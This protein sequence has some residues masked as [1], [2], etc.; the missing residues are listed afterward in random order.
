M[1]AEA[2]QARARPAKTWRRRFL[3]P[4][5][6]IVAVAILWP[7]WANEPLRR[8][9]FVMNVP[10]QMATGATAVGAF[11]PQRDGLIELAIR[12]PRG[13]DV[14]RNFMKAR[15]GPSRGTPVMSA[16]YELRT[17]DALVASDTIGLR[18]TGWGRAGVVVLDFPAY[19]VGEKPH[20][21]SV[22]L[23]AVPA[24]LA[25]LSAELVAGPVGDWIAYAWLES[26]FRRATLLVV[27]VA[28][29]IWI[30][31]AQVRSRRKDAAAE[32]DEVRATV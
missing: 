21:A 1:V 27:F 23:D 14:V 3:V 28:A 8:K 7:L 17:G 30:A 10:I 6:A 31:I 26:L 25:G 19:D 2:G 22:V 18:A 13:G 32:R 29:F 16:S 11:T 12:L 20:T 4:G 24:E 5:L 9:Q 15:E